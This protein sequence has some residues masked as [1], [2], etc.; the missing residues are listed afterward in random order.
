MATDG[1]LHFFQAPYS[2]ISNT[3]CQ[4][5]AVNECIPEICA[6]LKNNTMANHILNTPYEIWMAA[7]KLNLPAHLG[8]NIHDEV[9]IMY[10]KCHTACN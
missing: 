1:N 3:L 9:N 6:I 4:V 2:N 5:A 7:A 8:N 10:V